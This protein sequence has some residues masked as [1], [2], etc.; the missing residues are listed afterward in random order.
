MV[1]Q[2]VFLNGYSGCVS[3]VRGTYTTFTVLRRS[4]ELDHYML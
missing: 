4:L 2:I 3:L 1:I